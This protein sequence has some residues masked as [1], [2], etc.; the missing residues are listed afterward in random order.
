MSR[1]CP[2]E[3]IIDHLRG[4]GFHL[5]LEAVDGGRRHL[6][7]ADPLPSGEWLTPEEDAQVGAYASD[8]I[9]H[10][11][12]EMLDHAMRTFADT[13][14]PCGACRTRSW[15]WDPLGQRYVCRRCH[16]APEVSRE[17]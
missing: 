13:V 5:H 14:P 3:R 6:L 8:I 11:Q 1:D 7:H 15:E 4:R 12:A 10:L 17:A 16:P 2:A 9:G